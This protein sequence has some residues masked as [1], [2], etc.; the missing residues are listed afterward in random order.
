L[1]W[2]TLNP[3][4]VGRYWLVRWPNGSTLRICGAYMN[5]TK[6]AIQTWARA[7]GKSF[8]FTGCNNGRRDD[9]YVYPVNQVWNRGWCRGMGSANAFALTTTQHMY[10]VDCGAVR[11]YG[12]FVLPHEVGHLFGMCDQYRGGIRNC[13][14]TTRPT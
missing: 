13:A 7:I 8:K 3:G 6:S 9:I 14:R 10:I 12:A 2:G 4:N 1:K 5:A 11:R